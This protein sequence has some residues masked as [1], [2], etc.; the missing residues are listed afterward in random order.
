[1]AKGDDAGLPRD[2]LNSITALLS[3]VNLQVMATMRTLAEEENASQES[4]TNSFGARIDAAFTSVALA[5]GEAETEA[6]SLSRSLTAVQA[7]LR[8]LKSLYP[9]KRRR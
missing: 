1:M 5:A 6:R 2:T 8:K 4:K 7:E 9:P 3:R